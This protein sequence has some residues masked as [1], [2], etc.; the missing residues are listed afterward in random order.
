MEAEFMRILGISGSLRRSSFNTGLLRYAAHVAG[1][2]HDIAIA[3]LH[4]L[5]LF[6]EDIEAVGA[7]E[8]VAAFRSE[9]TAADALLIA[10]TEYNYGMSGVLKNAIDWASRPTPLSSPSGEQ[11]PPPGAIYTIPP[12]PLSGKAVGIMGASAGIGGTIRAQLQLRQSLQVNSALP[13][14]QPEAF[15]TFAFSG[16]FDPVTG[17]LL[18]QQTQGYVRAIVEALAA[19]T[20]SL[21]GRVQAT[22]S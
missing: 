20:T 2:E 4:E 10:C 13:M 18:D 1:K 12:S 22:Q 19:W 17:D 21:P 9:I 8:A 14:P 7:P 3:D 16:K 11:A 6:D 15:V 5:P